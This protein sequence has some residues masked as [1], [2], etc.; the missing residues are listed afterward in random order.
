MVKFAIFCGTH[1]L[2]Q[3]YQ[4]QKMFNDYGVKM[5]VEFY[6]YDSTTQEPL[7]DIYITKEWTLREVV[8]FKQNIIELKNICE[9]LMKK[10]DIVM[11]TISILEIDYIMKH[12]D[13]FA[14]KQDN[15]AFCKD[16]FKIFIHNLGKYI[17]HAT[18]TAR[19][20]ELQKEIIELE[21]NNDN[22][23]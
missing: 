1:T 6:E 17:A 15:E 5:Q 3:G 9:S 23:F 13:E 8:A 12:V 16:D 4:I 20:Q 14:N 21:Q 18:N 11:Y 10:G 2:K 22:L 19:I 7:N